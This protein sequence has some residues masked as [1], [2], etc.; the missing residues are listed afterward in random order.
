[1]PHITWNEDFILGIEPFDTHH[2]H[3]I[4]LINETTSCLDKNAP[5]DEIT[6][7]L[8]SLIDYAWY[9]F[10][11]EEKWMFEHSYPQKEEHGKLHK[12]F[13]SKILELQSQLPAN[14]KEVAEELSTYLNFWLIDHIVICDSHYASFVGTQKKPVL[15]T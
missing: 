3:L 12:Q 14:S 7:V 8:N 6:I 5:Q 13:A 10:N 11:A 1:M 15:M 2:Q 4:S 9:H